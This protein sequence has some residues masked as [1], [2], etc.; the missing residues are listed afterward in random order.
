MERDALSHGL[1]PISNLLLPLE[2]RSADPN[3]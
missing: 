2:L 3:C 1:Q